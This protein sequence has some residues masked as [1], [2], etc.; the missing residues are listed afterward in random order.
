LTRKYPKIILIDEPELHLNR[1]W[2]QTLVH[3]L[4]ENAPNNQYILATHSVEVAEAVEPYQRILL[5][6]SI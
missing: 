1:D 4:V 2:Q 6:S 5:E 3:D